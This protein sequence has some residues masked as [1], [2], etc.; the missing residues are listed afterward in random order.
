[1]YEKSLATKEKVYGLDH[2]LVAATYSNMGAVYIEQ[3]KY[4]EALDMFCNALAIDEKVNG[5]EH[6]DVAATK[7]CQK[8]KS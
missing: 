5:P 3:T 1:M 7:V 6:P 2:P 8:K 4:P